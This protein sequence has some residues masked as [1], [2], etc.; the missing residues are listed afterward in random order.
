MAG[1]FAALIFLTATATASAQWLNFPTPG[2]PRTAAGKPNLTA[3]VPH[4]VDGKPDLSGLWILNAGPG[5]TANVAAQLKPGDVEP[6]ADAVYKQRLGDLGRDDPW[7]AQCLPAG[8]REILSGGGGP[9]RIIQTPAIVAIL[10]EDLSYRQIFLDGRA[11]PKDPNPSWMG[12]SVGHWEGDTLVVESTGFNERSWLD[13]GGHPH[14]EALRTTERFR[15]TNFGHI[16]LQVTF[17]DPRAYKTPW[18]ISFGANLAPDTEMLESVCAENER[19]RPHLVGRTAEEKKVIVPRE[20]LAKYVGI[21]QTV[22]TTGT[23]MSARTFNFTLEGDQL[24]LEIGGN[25][26]IPLV[27]L[28][29]TSFSPR[30]LGTYEFSKDAQGEFT[31]MIAYSTEGDVEAVRKP[32]R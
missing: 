27:P 3:P 1:T 32:A 19:D 24:M 18:T 21:Y 28:S 26:R 2:L 31:R 14:T 10:Y 9:A 22:E 23:A 15:R 8:P 30:L 7:T 13:M 12:Y 29:E 6:W 16:E 4:A 11:L 25:G 17:N 20:V 5:H